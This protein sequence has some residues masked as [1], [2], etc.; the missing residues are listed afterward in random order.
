MH[1]HL[2]NSRKRYQRLASDH[3]QPAR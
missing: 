3:N 2:S 1:S